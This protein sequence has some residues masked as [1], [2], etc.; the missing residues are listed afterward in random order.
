MSSIVPVYPSAL[1]DYSLLAWPND[2]HSSSYSHILPPD[3]S[4]YQSTV[5]P[6]PQPIQNRSATQP[7]SLLRL[8]V[9]VRSWNPQASNEMDNQSIYH[10]THH[11]PTYSRPQRYSSAPTSHAYAENA[12][13]ASAAYS[14][15]M[16][17][18]NLVSSYLPQEQPT[19][20]GGLYHAHQPAHH[21]HHQLAQ[22]QQNYSTHT[23]SYAV[24]PQQTVYAA[25]LTPGLLTSSTTVNGYSGVVDA[26]GDVQPS[27]LEGPRG[28]QL[29]DLEGREDGSPWCG[30]PSDVDGSIS[31]VQNLEPRPYSDDYGESEIDSM[32]EDVDYEDDEEFF[33]SLSRKN[34]RHTR[35]RSSTLSSLGSSETS[36]QRHTYRVRRY[37][38]GPTSASVT[39]LTLAN[40][41]DPNSS[42]A[43]SAPV[44]SSRRRPR[45]T[46][47]LPLPVPVPHL[48]KKSRGRRVPTVSSLEDLSTGFGKKKGS[49]G[50]NSRVY[51]CE[52][53][54][55]GKCFARGEH[56]KR[57]VR[58]IHT[59]EK[60]HQC[61]YPHCG[62]FF[63]RHDNLGQHMRVHKDYI[64]PQDETKKE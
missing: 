25:E 61:P 14:M 18:N 31:M 53:D 12:A 15:S 3:P 63:S 59:Y 55:C 48:T 5:I 29:R 43:T 2:H 22:H 56:L 58:S 39:F 45:A 21:H 38:S 32:E 42:T 9:D 10:Q 30:R 27:G 28:D 34:E 46:S 1:D 35:Q 11:K 36:S 41:S 57:H 8:G 13:H 17:H 19:Y 47:A 50:K 64:P 37:H 60:P 20:S 7:H 62:K 40:G 23:Q 44:S 6:N 4:F 33:P 51:L 54:G 26:E 52:I 49:S 16:H 24:Q